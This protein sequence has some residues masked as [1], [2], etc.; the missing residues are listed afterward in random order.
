MAASLGGTDLLYDARREPDRQ[1]GRG[2]DK[3]NSVNQTTSVTPAGGSALSM[4]YTGTDS[5]ERT[6]AGSTTFANSIFGVA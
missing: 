4:A 6:A 3:Y 2:V 5:T 1:L